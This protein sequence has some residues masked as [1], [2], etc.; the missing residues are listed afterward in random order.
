MTQLHVVLRSRR[1]R[2][3]KGIDSY[4]RSG[5]TYLPGWLSHLAS[6]TAWRGL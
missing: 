5:A 4:D 1:G 6:H 3:R 2:D